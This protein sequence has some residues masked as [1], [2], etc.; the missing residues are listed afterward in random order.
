MIYRSYEVC[1][2]YVFFVYHILSY[3][4]V[5]IF[6]H[7]MYGCTFCMRLFNFVI[8]VF[9]LV[10]LCILI[11]MYA[12]FCIFCFHCVVLCKCVLYYCH[13]VPTQVQLTN[14]ST[15]KKWSI[16]KY[17]RNLNQCFLIRV[18][19][20]NVIADM[21]QTYLYS[22]CSRKGYVFWH[23]CPWNVCVVTRKNNVFS[24]KYVVTQILGC[25]HFYKRRILFVNGCNKGGS[26]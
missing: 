21:K 10:C 22:L 20:F 19:L 4:F 15:W 25:E 24:W 14:I 1:C 16:E 7:C 5:S 17:F 6:Y 26:S 2:L 18:S 23:S 11:V 12:L 3:S 8:Y 13:R 9:L